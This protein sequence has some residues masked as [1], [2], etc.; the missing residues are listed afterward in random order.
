MGIVLDAVFESPGVP[1]VSLRYTAAVHPAQ[2]PRGTRRVGTARGQP[3]GV[4][5]VVPIATPFPHITVH[6]VKAIAIPLLPTHGVSVLLPYVLR[7][8]PVPR[9]LAEI[10][11]RVAKVILRRRL[12]SAAAAVLPLR[13]RR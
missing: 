2:V 3:A 10:G 4:S 12:F 11:I 5:V 13:F 9:V 1:Q 8:L 7:V 6:V